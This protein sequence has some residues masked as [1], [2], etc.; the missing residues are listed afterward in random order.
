MHWKKTG[1]GLKHK[2]MSHKKGAWGNPW[3]WGWIL[4]FNSVQKLGRCEGCGTEE[5]R[6]WRPFARLVRVWVLVWFDWPVTFTSYI[7][8]FLNKKWERYLFG[9]MFPPWCRFQFWIQSR[10]P[11]AWMFWNGFHQGFQGVVTSNLGVNHFR[12]LFCVRGWKGV[13][14]FK[15]VIPQR[16]LSNSF[17]TKLY[18][19]KHPKIIHWKDGKWFY[20]CFIFIHFQL[21]IQS[22]D[23]LK[24]FPSGFSGV[25][26]LQHVCKPF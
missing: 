3:T 15:S 16:Y 25:C 22:R 11:S 21:W 9:Q 10:C 1:D 17:P 7:P 14:G 2:N 4:L 12:T 24:W 23:V 20:L 18:Q 26:D 19:K 6:A 13:R 8:P 5:D